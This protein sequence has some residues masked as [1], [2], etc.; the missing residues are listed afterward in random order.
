MNEILVINKDVNYTSRD[1]VNVLNKYFKTKKIG[2]TGTLDPIATGV[3]VVCIGR[4]TKLV[5]LI[6]SFDKEYI[7]EIKLGIKT[8]T[9]DITGN[10]LETKEYNLNEEIIKETLK[11]FIG[12]QLQT[13]PIYSAIKVNGKKLYEY[14]RNNE[15]VEIPKREIEIKRIELL[16][17]KNDIIKFKCEVSKGTYIRSLIESIC[18]KMGTVGTMNSL[19]R[20]RQGK[21]KI[22]D[23]YT[24]KDIEDNKYKFVN[25]EDI[26]DYEVINLEENMYKK[27]VNGSKI[28]LKS[29]NDKVLL[30]YNGEL[31]AIY[32]KNDDLFKP[33]VMLK[34]NYL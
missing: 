26:L 10:V 31:I 27:V 4:Y 15:S 3:L 17:F 7:A 32:E 28:K 12:V 6:T 19:V 24:L 33:L 18:K 14:A 30:K 21:F 9:L 2:H 23:S 1:V 25:V 5:N 22:E 34:N 13:P 8:D 11:S 29:N 20:T 16:E